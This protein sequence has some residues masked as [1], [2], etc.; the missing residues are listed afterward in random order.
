MVESVI[1]IN[2]FSKTMASWDFKMIKMLKTLVEGPLLIWWNIQFVKFLNLCPF[3]ISF[4]PLSYISIGVSISFS[5]FDMLFCFFM[6]LSPIIAWSYF[7]FISG[8]FAQEKNVLS[9]YFWQMLREIIKVK[10]DVIRV[11]NGIRLAWRK[12]LE[13]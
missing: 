5:L 12:K 2:S 8:L 4:S 13:N 9:P 1:S 6:I 3:I 7:N 10:Q 11:Q